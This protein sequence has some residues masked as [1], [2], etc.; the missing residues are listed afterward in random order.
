[1]K[2]SLII[3]SLITF[4]F[5]GYSQTKGVI[6]PNPISQPMTLDF[7]K[8]GEPEV[9]KTQIMTDYLKNYQEKNAIKPIE[10]PYFGKY[11]FK[12]KSKE[13]EN[14]DGMIIVKPNLAAMI[15][16]PVVKPDDNI[17]YHSKIVN[18]NTNKEKPLN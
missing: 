4:S 15:K 11:D 17:Y 16:M 2:K 18:S 9:P 5:A 7:L 8:N 3:L 13:L 14:I 1:M 10:L 6:I 12:E